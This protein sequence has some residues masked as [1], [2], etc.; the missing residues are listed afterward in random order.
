MWVFGIDPGTKGAI[1]YLSGSQGVV[2]CWGTM[3]LDSP[4][5][6]HRELCIVLHDKIELMSCG[7]ESVDGDVHAWIEDV[8]AF[9]GQGV[10]SCFTFG[11][12]FGE[13][14]AIMLSLGIPLNL[15]SPYR[16]QKELGCLSRGKKSVTRKFAQELYPKLEVNDRIAD[17]L[18][19]ATYGWREM[20]TFFTPTKAKPGS[21]S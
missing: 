8:H 1:A 9:P 3:A 4:R 5:E 10:S 2:T 12:S 7:V 20:N 11:R 16:W 21:K 6:Y 19:I 15:V 14:R 13:F 18:L 17:A